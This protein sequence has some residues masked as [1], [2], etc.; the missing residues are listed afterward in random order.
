MH[1]SWLVIVLFAATAACGAGEGGSAT[2]AVDRAALLSGGLRSLSIETYATTDQSG[3]PVDCGRLV[4]SYD[5]VAAFVPIGR[6]ALVDLNGL[7]SV[8][9]TIDRIPPG[10]TLFL[11]VGYDQPQGVG[12]ITH[13]GCGQAHIEKG[14]EAQVSVKLDPVP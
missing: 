6:V 8:D 13:A 3:A 2:F 9:V 1:R 5:D 7:P 11:V 12:T 14:V 4:A 10:D